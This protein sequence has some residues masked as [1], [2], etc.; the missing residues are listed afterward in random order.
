M[1]DNPFYTLVESCS[2]FKALEA[3][4]MRHFFLQGGIVV[5]P[6]LLCSIIALTIIVERLLFYTLGNREDEDQLRLL[7]QFLIRGNMNE[8]KI[9]TARLH[10]AMGRIAGAVI[11]QLESKGNNRAL[12]ENAA[13]TAGELEIKNLQRGLILLDTIVTASPL[14]GLLGTVT[15]IIKSFQ[16]LAVAG[17]AQSVQLSAGI[18]EALYNTAFGLAIAIPSLFMVNIFYGI[19]DRKAKELTAR[20]QKLLAILESSAYEAEA[21]A[22]RDGDGR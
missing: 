6:L 10:S 3:E 7:R 13:Q 1:S 11:K 18:A 9:L 8:A 14:L 17:G 16:A 15:G 4:I 21:A 2:K 22:G 19:A 12:L 20:S 5:Y